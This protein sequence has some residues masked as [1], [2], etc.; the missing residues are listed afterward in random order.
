M[1][2]CG[3]AARPLLASC[4]CQGLLKE[5]DAARAAAVSALAAAEC[6]ARGGPDYDGTADGD[7]AHP[8]G[9]GAAAARGRGLTR[10]A[11][12]EALVAAEKAKA[13]SEL[14]AVRLRVEASRAASLAGRAEVELGA[15]SEAL[16]GCQRR[17][18]TLCLEVCDICSPLPLDQHEH[19]QKNNNNKKINNNNSTIKNTTNNNTNEQRRHRWRPSRAPRSS[20]RWRCAWPRPS[21]G[22]CGTSD[23][24]SS[25]AQ[26]RT[27]RGPQRRAPWPQAR[28]ATSARPSGAQKRRP[29]RCV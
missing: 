24:R 22:P 29:R 28:C 14:E 25:S 26:R 4:L 16:D 6:E 10:S 19:E 21:S 3:S 8:A 11:A 18:G 9:D 7:A 13:S 12:L 15:K 5:S 27:A 1:S 17:I 20:G 23:P 2:A